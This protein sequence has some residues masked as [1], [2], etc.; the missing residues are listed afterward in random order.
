ML[1]IEWQLSKH[2]PLLVT[3]NKL[4]DKDRMNSSNN[5]KYVMKCYINLFDVVVGEIQG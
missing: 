2:Q 5:N 3:K 1:F 4:T